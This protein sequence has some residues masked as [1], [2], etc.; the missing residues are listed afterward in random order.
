[1][2]VVDRFSK[3]AHF[4][5]CK[6][7]ADAVN[8]ANL[9]FREVVKLHGVPR[10]ITSDRDVKFVSHFWQVLWRKFDTTLNMSS[11]YHPQS[12][13]QIEVVNLTFEKYDSLPCW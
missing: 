12:D 5:P 6:K 3:M 10:T 13:G 4:I 11:A 1:M 7:T 2:V 8:V 9:F